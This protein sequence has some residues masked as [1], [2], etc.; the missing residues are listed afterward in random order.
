MTSDSFAPAG[1]AREVSFPAA[2]IWFQGHFPGDPLLPGIAQLHV[3]METIRG[4]TQA[5]IRLTGLK[6]VRF[7]RI[8]RPEEPIDVAVEAVPEK[9]GFYR[10][11]LTV[12]GQTACSG[13]M[14]TTE[15]AQ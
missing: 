3:V 9:P 10:F 7:K 12:A 4:A 8:I 15:I 6:R 14:T 2:S 11:L 5:D 13:L 1:P